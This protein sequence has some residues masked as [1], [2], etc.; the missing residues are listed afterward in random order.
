ME[1]GREWGL[2][3]SICNSLNY[4]NC[5]STNMYNFYFNF[6]VNRSYLCDRIIVHLFSSVYLSVWRN[7]LHTIKW[8][9]TSLFSL[10]PTIHANQTP[11]W[12]WSGEFLQEITT[13]IN[14]RKKCT[15]LQYLVMAAPRGCSLLLSAVPTMAK[16][17]WCDILLLSIRSFTWF[18]TGVPW[19]MVPVLS[20]TTTFT[21]K[22]IKIQWLDD[23]P[24]HLSRNKKKVCFDKQMTI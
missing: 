4:L 22:K 17:L 18:T 12:I 14:K 5:P 1:G 6:L 10:I 9:N 15:C 13:L 23:P 11:V 20:N 8:E 19:V 21:C 24:H 2:Q 3:F 7:E 16:I